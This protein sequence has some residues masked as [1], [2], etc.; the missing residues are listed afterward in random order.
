MHITI[1]I[2]VLSEHMPRLAKSLGISVFGFVTNI[3]QVSILISNIVAAPAY[4]PNNI[5]GV[6]H[7]L[8]TLYSSC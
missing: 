8:H 4:I 5:V 1:G 7:F 6:S 2:R 3:Y